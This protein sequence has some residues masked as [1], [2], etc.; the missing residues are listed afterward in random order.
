[1]CNMLHIHKSSDVA[2]PADPQSS[3]TLEREH[4]KRVWW[5]TFC[6]DNMT[7][8]QMGVKP[9]LSAEQ[10][11]SMAYPAPTPISSSSS[12]AADEDSSF[13]SDSDY[14][15][16]RV[17]LTLLQTE[18][19]TIE[20]H[21]KEKGTEMQ[22]RHRVQR[23]EEWRAGWPERMHLQP[24]CGEQTGLMTL[25]HGVSTEHEIRS[26]ANLHLR[27]NQVYIPPAASNSQ[28]PAG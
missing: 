4:I 3:S 20:A 23:L 18:K 9:T 27:S 26:L 15:T 7:S 21:S 10:A 19:A 1:M 16:A 12:D 11:A 8:T 28:G 25:S 6:L 13:F 14:L 22:I 17:Q 5:S 24:R 2:S